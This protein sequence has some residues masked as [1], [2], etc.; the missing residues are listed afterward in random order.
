MG[1]I[2]CRLREPSPTPSTTTLFSVRQVSPPPAQV[3]DQVTRKRK[4]K[5]LHEKQSKKQKKAG[6]TK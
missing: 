2:V 3:P 1:N 5:E 4:A 6:N